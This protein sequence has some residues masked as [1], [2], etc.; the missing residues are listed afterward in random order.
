MSDAPLPFALTEDDRHTGLWL[1]LKAH[2]TDELDRA[3]IKND[4]QRSA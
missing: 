3:R 4:R 2:L 1:R